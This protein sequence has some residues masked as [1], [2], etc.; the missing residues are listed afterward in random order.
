MNNINKKLISDFQDL[1]RFIC[2]GKKGENGIKWNQTVS[3]YI[4]FKFFIVILLV[5]TYIRPNQKLL[6]AIGASFL[7]PYI[8][9]NVSFVVKVTPG[10]KCSVEIIY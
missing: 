5:H 3:S 2:K 10:L 9:K 4:Q 1:V 8:D 6:T 7:L